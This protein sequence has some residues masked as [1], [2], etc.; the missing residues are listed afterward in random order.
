VADL[1]QRPGADRSVLLIEDDTG[2]AFLVRELMADV[3]PS[4][5]IEW[6]H[7][8]KEAKGVLPGAFDCILI[9]LGLPD[10]SGLDGL[11]SVL[12]VAPDLPVIVLTGLA[13]ED[14]GVKALAIGAQDYLIKGQVDGPLLSRSRR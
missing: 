9:D 3:D 14:S 12:Q 8:L 1:D 5:A 4:L 6:V 13:Q 2:D 7:S 10:A 11:V